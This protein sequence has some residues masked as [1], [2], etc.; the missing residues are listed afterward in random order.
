MLVDSEPLAAQAYVRVYAKHGL[1]ITPDV[2]S[3]CIGMKQTD[4]LRRIHEL[5]GQAFPLEHQD[6][7]WSETRLVFR[8]ALEPVP[9]I[10]TFLERLEVPCCVASSS[11]IERIQFS[12]NTTGLIGFFKRNIFSSSMVNRG[13]PVPDLILLAAEKMGVAPSDCIVIEDPPFGVQGAVA[14]GMAVIGFTGG[15]HTTPGH[16]DALQAAGASRV[17]LSW[18]DIALRTFPA[19]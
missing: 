6:D 2:I 15:G 1:A 19:L 12:L 18:Q 7:I 8:K 10:K 5:T 16:G 17:Y 13:K 3:Q 14:A 4:I 11:S 9:G